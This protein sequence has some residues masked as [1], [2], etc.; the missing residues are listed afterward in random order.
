M[1]KEVDTVW[2]RNVVWEVDRD[3][4]RK[5]FTGLNSMDP[6][7]LWKAVQEFETPLGNPGPF[8]LPERW[9]NGPALV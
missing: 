9:T 7:E 8:N 4:L 3:E 2:R 5:K 6:D 1:V